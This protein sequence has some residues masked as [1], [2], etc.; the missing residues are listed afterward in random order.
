MAPVSLMNL[1][2][3]TQT[4]EGAGLLDSVLSC[5]CLFTLLS[6]AETFRRRPSVQDEKSKKWEDRHKLNKC[7]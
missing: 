6:I 7:Q 2:G 3:Q 5:G 1:S 4:L